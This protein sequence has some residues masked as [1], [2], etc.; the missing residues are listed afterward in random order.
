MPLSY[1]WNGTE[2]GSDTYVRTFEEAQDGWA[3]TVS[4]SNTDNTVISVVCPKVKTTKGPE[5]VVEAADDFF[6]L[7]KGESAVTTK[8]PSSWHNNETT[9]NC[10]LQCDA[11]ETNATLV[12]AKLDGVAITSVNGNNFQTA[13]A[14][15]KTINSSFILDLPSASKCKI[16][17]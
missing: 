6:E 10:H 12:G 2:A 9:G 16:F 1:L 14:I 13:L 4:V 17:W 15:S 11:T 8:L 5:Y 7:P 3:P